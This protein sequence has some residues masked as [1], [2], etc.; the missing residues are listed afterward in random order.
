RNIAPVAGQNKFP[1]N[2][3]KKCDCVW[4]ISY[5]G[6]DGN[7]RAESSE[8]SR[9][10]DAVRLLQRRVGARD[11]NLPVI[12]R[13]EQLTFNDAAKAVIDDFTVNGKRSI[14]MVKRRINKHLTPYFDGLRLVG[15]TT[16]KVTAYVAHRQ[17][18]GIQRMKT[19]A[20]GESGE[21]E[22]R[23]VRVADV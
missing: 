23:L 11:N 9:K 4:W 17:K 19:V 2:E 22:R 16:D 6:P 14:A 12:P 5:L 15:I 1:E 21:T 18:Q 13:A 7:R 3:R 20:V 8:S 10:G